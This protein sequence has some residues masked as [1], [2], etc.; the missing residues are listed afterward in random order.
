[1]YYTHLE[2]YI[3]NLYLSLAVHSPSQL[4]MRDIAKKLN[5]RLHYFDE[6]SESNFLGG[7]PRIFLNKNLNIQE[8]WQDFAHELCHVLLHAGNQRFL[9]H[10]FLLYQEMKANN[11]MYHFCIPTF[12]LEKIDLPRYKNESIK[13]IAETF[14]VTLIFAEKRLEMYENK[15]FAHELMG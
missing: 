15:V 6:E 1:M 9:P 2:D 11:F 4:D 10:N 8:Q 14:N 5:I 12:M 7:V 3:K 13:L